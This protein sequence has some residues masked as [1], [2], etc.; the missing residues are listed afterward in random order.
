MTTTDGASESVDNAA[1]RILAAGRVLSG[2]GWAPAGSGNYSHRLA[3][4]D[5]AITVSG[6]HKA[7]LSAGDVMT[8]DAQG[9]ARDD[10][11]PSAETPLHLMIYRLYPDVQAVLHT[12]SIPVVALTRLAPGPGALRLAGYELLKAFP[13]VHTHDCAV[14]LPI[15]DNRQDMTA[16]AADVAAALTAHPAPAFLVRSHGLYGW[17]SSMDEAL[18]V[19][20]AAETMIA[21]ELELSRRERP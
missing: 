6:A 3:D 7:R 17:G 16:L 1:D 20:E 8:V 18:C 10:R 15:F 21:C 13:G 4:G 2:R 9:R 5:I 11:R 19:V 14:D 12:H